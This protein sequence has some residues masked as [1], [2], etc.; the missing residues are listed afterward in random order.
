MV[1]NKFTKSKNVA[2]IICV[3]TLSGCMR[4]GNESNQGAINEKY[5]SIFQ[6][7]IEIESP[8]IAKKSNL[9]P[10]NKFIRKH[11]EKVY[12]TYRPEAD[13]WMLP[14]S[15]D[16]D[17][18]FCMEIKRVNDVQIKGIAYKFVEANGLYVN[19]KNLIDPDGG[20]HVA[21][22]MSGLFV[23]QQQ[24]KDWTLVSKIEEFKSETWG[25][26]GIDEKSFTQFGPEVYGWQISD[27]GM[28]QGQIY[29]G[30]K[31]VALIKD[32][33][34]Q[35]L[36]IPISYNADGYDNKELM[37][38]NFENE[39]KINKLEIHNGLYVIDL[40]GIKA[41]NYKYDSR[42]TFNEDLKIYE[43]SSALPSFNF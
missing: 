25:R 36:D 28:W 35:I 10:E 7:E 20:P 24:N 40:T 39:I 26:S 4:Q 3:I 18:R 2:I 9:A 1:F 14:K 22:G 33:L 31:Y 29:Q 16:M 19:E 38:N 27:G 5:K 6:H 41:A 34:L 12:G 32:N 23:F 13:C 8:S 21:P 37:A 15:P 42:I 17:I 30:L 11:M 43:Y